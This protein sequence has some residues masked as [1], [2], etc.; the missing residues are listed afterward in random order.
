M[1]VR[2]EK[3]DRLRAQGVDPYPL[4]VPRTTTLGE[5]RQRHPDLAPDTATGETVSVAGRIV[6]K[7]DSGKLCFATLRDGTSELQV[8]LPVDRLG[9]ASLESW[10]R[11]IDLGD[12]VSVTGEVISSRR[13]ELS[14]RA[15]SWLLASKA[16]RPLPKWHGL[17]AEA[18]V[19][20][21]YAELAVNPEARA[22]VRAKATVLAS[23]R[24]TLAR[25]EFVEAET[26]VLQFTNGGAAARPFTTHLNAFDTETYLRIALELP[27]KRLVVGG[28]ERVYEIGRTFR[29]EGIDTTHNPEFTMLEAYEAYGDYDTMAELTRDLVVSAAH[30]MGS[31]VVPDG[32]GGEI[33]L[34][35]PWRSVTVHEAVSEA[36]GRD[37]DPATPADELQA[38]AD[39]RD[40]ALQPGWSAGEIVLEL[41]EKLVE[42]TLLE[43]TFV[44]DYPVEVRPLARSHRNDPR[45]TEAWD[46]II[47]GVELAPAY[48]PLVDPV[49][50][51]RRLTE[52]SVK[53]AGGR[54]AAVALD[55]GFL[56][57][58]GDGGPP[59]GGVGPGVGRVGLPARAGVRRAPDGRDGPRRGP[60]G[61]AAHRREYPRGD[62][63]PAGAAGV[64]G[65]SPESSYRAVLGGRDFRLLVAG[66]AASQ[67]GDWLYN[68][69]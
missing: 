5:V 44:R 15:D 8:M 22:L 37:I 20:Q 45:L 27:L 68:V 40:V 46:L 54:P 2:R 10:K 47:G 41:F 57:A 18:K 52:Q 53:A 4:G 11:D 12:H 35:K 23:L 60:A 24:E 25:R 51:R 34:A 55:E 16:L 32:H 48:S 38:I 30:A 29:N 65:S 61:H 33:D 19:R 59:V 17:D 7:R 31:T 69:A 67:V 62:Y 1:R 49:E 13:G 21:R 36:V 3:L 66:G 28:I 50:Q 42:H 64:T 39:E 58:P 56:R 14:V 9:E 26:G 6:L 43:P 63:F